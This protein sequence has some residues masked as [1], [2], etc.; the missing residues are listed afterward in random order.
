MLQ[1]ALSDNLLKDKKDKNRRTA[2]WLCSLPLIF[3]NYSHKFS[4]MGI[5]N[6]RFSIIMHLWLCMHGNSSVWQTE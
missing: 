2:E 1:K 4:A 3:G 5:A 6:I